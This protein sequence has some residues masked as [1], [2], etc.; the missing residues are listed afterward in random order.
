M[1]GQL[2]PPGI[3]RCSACAHFEPRPGDTL[4][5]WCSRHA[6][7]AWS[8]P[9]FECRTYRPDD[10]AVVAL[11]RRRHAVAADL[12][13]HPETRYSFDVQ[14]ATPGGPASG[15][16]SVVLALRDSTGRICA[17]ELR[18]PPERWPGITLFSEFWRLAAEA[19]LP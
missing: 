10:A 9:L 17:G 15:P 6:V 13:A 19:R 12:K 8:A 5:G 7:E 11:A 16:V 3:A 4:D 18:V 2:P 1:T 14:G